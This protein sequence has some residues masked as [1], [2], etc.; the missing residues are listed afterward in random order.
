MRLCSTLDRD[1]EA[2]FLEAA[3]RGIPPDGG[4]YMPPNLPLLP[5]RIR[6]GNDPLSF[7]EVAFDIAQVLIGGEIPDDTL[8]RIIGETMNFPVPVRRLDESLAVLELFHGPTLAFKDFGARFL[9][10]ILAYHHH[11]SDRAT[12]VLVATSGDTGSAVARGCAGIEGLRVVLLFPA[13]KVSRIQELQ[14]TSGAPNLTALRVDGTFDD[15]QTMVKQ[16]FADRDLTTRISL[17][18]AN[19]I[20]IARLIPQIFYFVAAWREVRQHEPGVIFAVPSGNLGNLTAGVMAW[21]MGVPVKHFV[22]ATNINAVLPEYLRTGTFRPRPAQPT[23]SNAMDVGNPNNISR[24]RMLFGEDLLAMRSIVASDSCTDDETRAAIAEAYHR[25]RYLF[26]PHGAVA[27]RVAQRFLSEHATRAVTMILATAHP[28]KF[29]EA[30][31]DELLR[32]ISVPE[33]L[34]NLTA[35]PKRFTTLR[36]R[37]DELKSILLQNA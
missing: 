7:Q 17:T 15:C 5:D 25:Y 31:N 32:S 20:N 37:Y 34:R 11:G 26:D 30:Y 6:R 12:T 4:L 8:R 33:Q 23:L 2:S 1:H 35:R 18:S 19:S 13:G 21:K 22:A 16:A 10:R 28:A 3:A 24:L 29:P 27:Y 36:A 14:L 9:A